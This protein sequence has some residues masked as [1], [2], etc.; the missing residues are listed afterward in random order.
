[1]YIIT[2]TNLTDL[3]DLT[4]DLGK[5]RLHQ[6]SSKDEVWLSTR[7]IGEGGTGAMEPYPIFTQSQWSTMHLAGYK[8]LK[9]EGTRF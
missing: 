4:G 3:S 8:W 1:M 5:P 2:P 9:L 6:A 7:G